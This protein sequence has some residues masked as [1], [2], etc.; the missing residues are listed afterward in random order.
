VFV[1]RSNAVCATAARR[2]KDGAAS[3][4]PNPQQAGSQDPVLVEKYANSVVLPALQQ[5]YADLSALRPT[6]DTDPRVTLSE[7]EKAIDRW[8]LD[9]TIMATVNDTSFARFDALAKDFGMTTCA[10]TDAMVRSITTG[11]PIAT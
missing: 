6:S 10:A 2:I 1:A 8:E 5:E 11:E 7:L 3:V 4:F 9:K